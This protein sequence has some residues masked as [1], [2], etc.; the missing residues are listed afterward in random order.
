MFERIGLFFVSYLIHPST[1]TSFFFTFLFP[2]FSWVIVFFLL[3]YPF[4]SSS[5]SISSIPWVIKIANFPHSYRL[6]EQ[7]FTKHNFGANFPVFFAKYSGLFFFFSPAVS[8]IHLASSSHPLIPD[9]SAR[10]PR[11]CF[12]QSS[13]IQLL[14]FASSSLAYFP[15][16]RA[17]IR[18]ILVCFRASLCLFHMHNTLSN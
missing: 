5:S 12:V 18:S 1:A 17:V 16:Y 8:F 7:I 13:P 14:F 11:L 3:P 9:I 2:L 10:S 15:S 4:L 6:N